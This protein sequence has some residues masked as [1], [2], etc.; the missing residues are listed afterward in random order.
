M[1]QKKEGGQTWQLAD[2]IK[3][4]VKNLLFK[5]FI[6]TLVTDYIIILFV[7]RLSPDIHFGFEVTLNPFSPFKIC[8]KAQKDSKNF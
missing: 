4:S 1:K 2:I 5:P 7:Y 3:F 6:I 8:M